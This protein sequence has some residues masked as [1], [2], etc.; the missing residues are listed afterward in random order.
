MAPST[1]RSKLIFFLSLISP[2]LVASQD[3]VLKACTAY[4]S[5]V[6]VCSVSNTDAVRFVSC[7]CQQPSQFQSYV[8]DCYTCEQTTGNQTIV[9][10]FGSLLNACGTGMRINLTATSAGTSLETS[11]VG[12][13][14]TFPA[15]R[16]T[17]ATVSV[18]ATSTPTTSTTSDGS[19]FGNTI[20]TY[21]VWG[22]VIYSS[23]WWSISNF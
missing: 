18:R 1:T 3:C 13:N 2:I 21:L 16:T 6:S 10:G 4:I 7:L 5:T 14:F 15:T 11:S 23:L 9:N 12:S 20:A 17:P 8:Q 19:S 22:G